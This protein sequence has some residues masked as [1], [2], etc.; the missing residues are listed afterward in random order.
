[1]EL[2]R[3]EAMATYFSDALSLEL[4]LQDGYLNATKSNTND[5]E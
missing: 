2:P 3:S 1:M 5:S 4:Y